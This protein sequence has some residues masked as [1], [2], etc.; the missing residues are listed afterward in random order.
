MIIGIGFDGT[1]VTDEFPGIGKDIGA[2]PVLQALCQ[3]GHDLILLSTRM[4]DRNRNL[5]DLNDAYDWFRKN[6]IALWGVN[7]NPAQRTRAVS[8]RSVDS[9]IVEADIYIG[10][11]ALG[12][13]L[14]N[15]P[16]DIHGFVIGDE[17]DLAPEPDPLSQKPYVDWA[18][19]RF[20]LAKRG[21]L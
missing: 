2:V 21:L 1:V 13:P 9:R 14:R 17:N 18:K 10:V 7:E 5:H 11:Q 6:H 8:R 19:V 4:N 15:D 12:C 3:R 16:Y 20:M